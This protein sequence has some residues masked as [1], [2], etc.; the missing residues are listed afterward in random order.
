MALC[1]DILDRYVDNDAYH[2]DPSYHDDI[3]LLR[4][5]LTDVEHSMQRTGVTQDKRLAIL[6]IL[7]KGVPDAAKAHQRIADYTE[8]IRQLETQGP[9]PIFMLIGAEGC[10]RCGNPWAEQGDDGTCTACVDLRSD[11]DQ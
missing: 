5:A 1:D 10:G 7:I 9:R 3:Q 11:Q 4:R 6:E 2:N 8:R